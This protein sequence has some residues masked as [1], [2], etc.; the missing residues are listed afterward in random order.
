MTNDRIKP[1]DAGGYFPI[2]NY[3]FDVCMPQLSNAGWRVLCVAIRQTWGWIGKEE[4]QTAMG[5]KK[6][7]QISYSQFLQSSGMRSSASI[8]KGLQECIAHNYLVRRQIGIKPGIGSP[9]YAYSLNVDYEAPASVSEAID[10]DHKIPASENEAMQG[11]IA[12]ENEVGIASV[13]EDTKVNKSKSK[14]ESKDTVSKTWDA[15]L[16]EL[17]LQMTRQTYDTWFKGSQLIAVDNS[18]WTVRVK[19]PQAVEWINGRLMPVVERSMKRHAPGVEVEF[20][21][22]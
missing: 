6:W 21:A 13:S 19:H 2:H 12:S 16:T 20:V 14:D 17:A 4:Q 22:P 11:G 1:F 7:D 10:T 18:T 9:L 5:R 15:V 8:S 3:V